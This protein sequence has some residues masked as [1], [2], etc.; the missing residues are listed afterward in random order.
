MSLYILI[1]I[2]FSSLHDDMKKYLPSFSSQQ[3]FSQFISSIKKFQL[4]NFRKAVFGW[5]IVCCQSVSASFLVSFF[6]ETSIAI[7][8]TI[9]IM[10]TLLTKLIHQK[11][12]WF[13]DSRCYVTSLKARGWD[14]ARNSMRTL[15]KRATHDRA[16]PT[17]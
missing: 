3:I 6:T 12:P 5:S 4:L 15:S 16:A 10:F 8:A 7:C 11:S 13:A 9:P 14:I 2:H 1:N 17:V